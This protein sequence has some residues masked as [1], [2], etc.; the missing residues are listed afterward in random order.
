MPAADADAAEPDAADLR[1][2][3]LDGAVLALRQER[4]AGRRR[5]LAPN[6]DDLV[7]VEAAEPHQGL[8]IVIDEGDLEIIVV[9]GALVEAEREAGRADSEAADQRVREAGD[10]AGK[11]DP[12]GHGRARSR[13]GVA[14]GVRPGGGMKRGHV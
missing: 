12:A 11:I 5:E 1:E 2:R 10:A 7:L 9:G 13:F 4:K 14:R 6:G 8:A 3:M